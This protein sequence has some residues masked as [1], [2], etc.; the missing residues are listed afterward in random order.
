MA[1]TETTK[2]C[3]K[4]KA[5]LPVGEFNKRAANK[6]GLCGHCRECDN[7]RGKKYREEHQAEIRQKKREYNATKHGREVNYRGVTKYRATE[8]GQKVYRQAKRKYQATLK[9]RLGQIFSDMNHRCNNLKNRNYKY[10]GGRGI[11]NKFT[12]D[13]FRD[14]VTND[15]GINSIEQIQGLQ[16]DRIDNDGH[17]EKGNI[18]FV[19]PEVNVNNRRCSKKS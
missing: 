17:Y 2:H 9:G 5:D 4:C 14:Y 11:L 19:T 16:I 18:R 8:R 3:S 15:L 13:G 6:D 1:T 12:L 7:R 10:Y